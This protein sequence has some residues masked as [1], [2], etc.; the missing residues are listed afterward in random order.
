MTAGDA[1]ETDV[2]AWPRAVVAFSTF[3][4]TTG[5]EPVNVQA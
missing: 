2:L 1:G 5:T 3:E 4:V